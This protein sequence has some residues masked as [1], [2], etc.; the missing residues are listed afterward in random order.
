M[1]YFKIS[2]HCFYLISFL[3]LQPLS[4]KPWIQ[5]QNAGICVNWRKI[6]NGFRTAN[7]WRTACFLKGAPKLSIALILSPV[8]Q[9]VH[10][11]TDLVRHFCIFYIIEF[12]PNRN[13]P[14]E[15]CVWAKTV[16]IIT[17][18]LKYKP[19]LVLSGLYC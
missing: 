14:I 9:I 10:T 13:F 3:R 16:K 4:L 7:F 11:M 1:E 18:F 6:A 19:F 12:H 15:F 8:K 2:R 17:Q 5:F